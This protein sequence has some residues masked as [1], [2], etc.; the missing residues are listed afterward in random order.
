[1][2]DQTEIEIPIESVSSGAKTD[3]DLTALTNS[4]EFWPAWTIHLPMVLLG[5][6][7]GFRLGC[8]NFFPA[9]NP[10]MTNGGLFNYSKFESLS[11]FP[12]ENIPESIL[13]KPPHQ[14]DQLLIGAAQR[15]IGFPFILKPNIGE[16]G[17]GVSL[18]SDPHSAENYLKTFRNE[19]VIL[20]DFV[21]KKE[22]Y[23]IF[24]LKDPKTGKV[25]IPSITQKIPLQVMGNGLDSVEKLVQK[26]PR[27][28]RYIQEIPKDLMSFVPDPNRI[29]NLSI[30]GNHCKGAVFV[31]RSE[32]ITPEVISSFTKICQPFQDFFYG[33]LDI[34]VNSCLELSDPNLVSILEVNGANA[35]PIHIYSSGI[36]YFRSLGILSN[37][38]S[39]MAQIARFN[40]NSIFPKP[41]L[42]ALKSSFQSYQHLKKNT[43]E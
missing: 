26:H 15:G 14:L 11:D 16:R 40:L 17:R 43:H 22:E 37:F 18:I 19:A 30:K 3:S 23:G 38:F 28:K 24:I 12:K 25:K 29:F 36:S 7:Q 33:R 41:T 42:A 31:D 8:L 1:M 9:V 20:Q 10:G 32:L 13:S 4:F 5:I 27:A 39:Q 35:E 21:S 34:K 2:P 6:Y